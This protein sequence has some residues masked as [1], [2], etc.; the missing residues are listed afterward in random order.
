MD[1]GILKGVGSNRPNTSTQILILSFTHSLSGCLTSLS[2]N[3]LIYKTEV[4]IREILVTTPTD[5]GRFSEV[6]WVSSALNA[7]YRMRAHTFSLQ[8][9]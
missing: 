4:K 5:L 7:L 1:T 2:C 3:S 6:M 9:I 8:C